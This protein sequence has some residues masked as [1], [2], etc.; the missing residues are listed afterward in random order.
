MRALVGRTWWMA[1]FVAGLVTMSAVAAGAA[2]WTVE[3]TPDPGAANTVG[4]LVA[5]GPNDVWA[6]GSATSP[7]YAGCHSRAFATRWNGT[8][9]V[10]VPATGGPICASV[11]GVGG[12]ADSDVWAVGSANDGRATHIRHWDGGAWSTVADA[13]VAGP[14]PGRR[15]RTTALNGIVS[16]SAS[17]AWTVGVTEYPSFTLNTL[18]EH[19]N[20]SKWT[21][22]DAT[23]P[24]GSEL[25][26]VTALS[27]N[28][29][30]TVGEGGSSGSAGLATLTEHWNG[31]KWSIVPSPNTNVVN[32]LRGVS[33][34]SSNDV[35][36]VGESVKDSFDGVSVSSNLVEHWDGKH[37][38]V[39]PSPNVGPRNNQLDA[40]AARGTN[41]VWAAGFSEVVRGDI[42]VLQTLVMHWNGKAWKVVSTPDVGSGDNWLDS[43][44]APA[45]SHEVFASG[46]G[47]HGTLVLRTAG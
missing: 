4:G 40:V 10:S 19:W 21:A 47:P 33:G 9:F 39:V 45:G 3:P 35:W 32:F 29:L 12:S 7:S 31:S 2:S 6:V 11:N 23:G 8:A 36:A 5:F 26:A 25:N 41:D 34:A 15:L 22:V 13:N 42:P 18:V 44:V 30:W 38:S 1:A 17:N 24:K 27:P 37:W 20:G 43:V 28:D 46:T 14:A 16:L